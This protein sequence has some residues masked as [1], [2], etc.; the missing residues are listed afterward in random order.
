V[1][2]DALE[3]PHRTGRLEHPAMISLITDNHAA[4]AALCRE[5]GIRKLEVFGSVATDAFD[6]ASSDLDFIVDPGGYE[7]GVAGRFF[8]FADA[9]ES[10]LGRK[11][12]LI[13]EEQIQNPYFRH[14]VDR[15]RVTIHESGDRAKAA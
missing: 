6:E 5:Y 9:L 12:D 8:R 10:L 7:R 15:Q 1:H 3:K 11:V 2:N 4:I 14:A 13:T